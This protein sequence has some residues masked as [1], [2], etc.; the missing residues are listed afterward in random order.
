MKIHNIKVKDYR[1]FPG[2]YEF[3]L[4]HWEGRNLKG[5]KNLLVFGEN[6][7]GK[8]SLFHAL[9]E[10]LLASRSNADITAH[11][12][13]FVTPGDP[14]VALELIGFEADGSRS[15]GSTTYEWALGATPH[16][17]PLIEAAAKS[18][19]CL[20]YRALLRTHYLHLEYDQVEIFGLL[21]SG[22]LSHVTNPIT[23]KFLGEEWQEIRSKSASRLYA[24][25]RTRLKAKINN[26]NQGLQA[27]LPDLA[28]KANE[29]LAIFDQGVTLALSW[30]RDAELLAN[31][32]RFIP[33]EINLS[34]TYGGQTIPAH[35]RLLNEA[36]LS[37][38]ALSLYF[39]SL[40][41]TP[42]GPFKV[43]VLDDVLIGL[44]MS[45]RF[46]VLKI[47]REHFPA[48]QIILLTHDRL[49]FEI[50]RAQTTADLWCYYELHCQPDLEH[51][52]DRPI[53][54]TLQDGFEE[55][56]ARADA[57]ITNHDERAAAVYARAAFEHWAKKYCENKRVDVPFKI[58]P[59]ALKINE[60]WQK[61]KTSMTPAQSAANQ[62]KIADL[63]TYR[64][65]VLNPLSHV[66]GAPVVDAEVMGAINAVRNLVTMT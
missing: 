24:R 27:M 1:G 11:K 3:N 16:G 28:I 12:N 30:E 41:L 7:S 23:G 53:H 20:D 57:H 8:S 43:I 22:L 62:A 25:E 47:L 18:R 13:I 29:L 45:N 14:T 38:M 15:L 40:L 42:T 51:G 64:R 2:E 35:H 19:G 4:G 36:R 31:P 37:A 55:L 32:K 54:R 39:A 10:F 66:A 17:Q 61:I 60:L 58:D 50:V 5:G 33:A 65:I 21:V 59:A 6:G 34:A 52:F 49:W 26:F 44:D 63:E 46:P 56:L 48:W 9:N